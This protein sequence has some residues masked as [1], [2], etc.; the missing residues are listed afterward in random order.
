M[1]SIQNKLRLSN[2]AKKLTLT[3]DLLAS[4]SEMSRGSL[5]NRITAT[6]SFGS[7]VISN[8]LP[9]IDVLD[10][11]RA[12]GYNYLP[13]PS[14]LLFKEILSSLT[15]EHLYI[16]SGS[17]PI[18]VSIYESSVAFIKTSSETY[19]PYIKDI[20]SAK[21]LIKAQTWSNNRLVLSASMG[22]NWNTNFTLKPISS[23]TEL[24]GSPTPEDIAS[25]LREAGTNSTLLLVGPSGNGKSALAYH[26]ATALAGSESTLLKIDN[27]TIKLCSASDIHQIVEWLQPDILLLDDIQDKMSSL[28]ELLENSTATHTICT[29][30]TDNIKYTSNA[31]GTLYFPGLRPG[32]VDEVLYIGL[33]DSVKRKQILNHYLAQPWQDDLVNELVEYTY[34]LSCA[35]LAKC[36]RKFE[37]KH[38]TWKQ[39]ID[40]IR[41]SAPLL[42]E[43][44]ETTNTESTTTEDTVPESSGLAV[45][46]DYKTVI[47]FAK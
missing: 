43:K 40:K 13:F 15:P 36:A 12:E 16:P 39:E 32:R 38:A 26:T 28:L 23:L 35:Y 24:I 2:I 9:D 19:G 41:L 20:N 34:G 14:T 33:P 21:K 27:S 46:N 45:I 3:K 44:K 8:L 11:V 29:Y 4:T 42:V 5:L 31:P 6:L 1:I 7:Q 30:M 47:G 22:T 18:D 37:Q 10:I 25:L 17:T